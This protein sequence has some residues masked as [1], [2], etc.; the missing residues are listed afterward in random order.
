MEKMWDL[1]FFWKEI[2]EVLLGIF[3]IF[4]ERNCRFLDVFSYMNFRSK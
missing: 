4:L 3:A 1:L 2:L